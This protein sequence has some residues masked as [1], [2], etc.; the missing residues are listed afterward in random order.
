[1]T[2]TIFESTAGISLEQLQHLPLQTFATN[3]SGQV[4]SAPL[5]W[6]IARD[7]KRLWFVASLPGGTDYNRQ[8][9]SGEFVEGLWEQD[10]A[11]L[12]IKESSGRYQEFNV[13]PGG[14]WWSVALSSYRTREPALP[15]L[16]EP[17]IRVELQEGRWRVVFGVDRSCLAVEL[18]DNSRLHVSGI[19]HKP[20]RA[21]LSSCPVPG[22]DPDFHHPDAFMPVR[23]QAIG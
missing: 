3:W 2:A 17:I 23:F 19:S 5:Q 1:M 11:E 16:R 21:F 9:S 4:L 22:V 7:Q 8:H 20:Q 10:V 13:S 14:A 15:E 18:T 12:F 6:A